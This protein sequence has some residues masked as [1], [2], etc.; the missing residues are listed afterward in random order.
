VFLLHAGIGELTMRKTFLY[1]VFLLVPLL[2]HA[3]G[4]II[5]RRAVAP[6]GPGIGFITYPPTERTGV[7]EGDPP[8]NTASAT[9][10]VVPDSGTKT[11]I[12]IGTWVFA[13]TS[14]T[15]T[16]RL[17]IFTHDAGNNNPDTMVSNSESAEL[18]TSETTIT[19][20]SYSYGTNP[21]VTGG[22]T[23]WL[24]Y[25]TSNANCNID[26]QDQADPVINVYTLAA[27]YPTWPT[28]GQWDS[29]SEGTEKASLYA[30]YQ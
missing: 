27:T 12:E 2:A 15:C 9:K 7:G 3:D 20:V 22:S 21:T 28:A 14:T 11:V 19:K 30:V 6:A 16:F 18:G 17:A 1:A 10:F 4:T 5:K 13:D 23:Y 8:A 24:V 26:G 29:G 25:F